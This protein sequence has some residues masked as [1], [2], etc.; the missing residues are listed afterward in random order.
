MAA[1]SHD[2]CGIKIFSVW[3]IWL[4]SDDVKM[5][6]SGLRHN[7][8]LLTLSLTYCGIDD[9]GAKHVAD[10]LRHNTTIE[11]VVLEDNII[12][13]KGALAIGNALANN[14]KS[15][16]KEINCFRNDMSTLPD[17]FAFITSLKRLYVSN[18]HINHPAKKLYPRSPHCHNDKKSNMRDLMLYL[19]NKRTSMTRLAFLFGLHKRLGNLSSIN[20]WL[21]RSSIFEP[22]LL[23]SI[24]ELASTTQQR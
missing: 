21:T 6:S 17:C 2:D 4:S 11:R 3:F 1:L 23:H 13:D 7:N 14:E 16:V 12:G 5:V 8:T 9:D 24:L 18:H 22:A 10:L 19:A 15:A 20:K